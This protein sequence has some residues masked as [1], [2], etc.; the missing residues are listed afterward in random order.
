MSASV[1]VNFHTFAANML[2]VSDGKCAVMGGDGV[3][4][5]SHKLGKT[6]ARCAEPGFDPARTQ[7]VY[8]WGVLVGMAGRITP[9]ESHTTSRARLHPRLLKCA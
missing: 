2:V 6:L 1:P 9:D 4:V 7:S 3:V 8:H 5:P